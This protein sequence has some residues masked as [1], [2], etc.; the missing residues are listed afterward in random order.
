[1]KHTLLALTLDLQ[2]EAIAQ[3]LPYSGANSTGDLI[4]RILTAVMALAALSVLLF[5]IWGAFDWINSGGEKSKIESARNKMTGAVTGMFVLA[6]VLVLFMFIQT[7]FGIEIIKIL[8]GPSSGAPA[9]NT[10]YSF[11]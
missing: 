6:A 1:M 7:V 10:Q 2:K 8:P 3:N 11:F 4:S 5:L 9:V